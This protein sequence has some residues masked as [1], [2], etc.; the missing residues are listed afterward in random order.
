MLALSL[1]GR[2]EQQ[3]EELVYKFFKYFPAFGHFVE[4]LIEVSHSC[5]SLKTQDKKG[6]N[7]PDGNLNLGFFSVCYSVQNKSS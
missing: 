3:E 5:L 6:Q 4:T 7:T 1:C 2:S